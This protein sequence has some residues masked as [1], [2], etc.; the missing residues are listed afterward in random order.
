MK[1]HI[2]A[3]M[4]IFITSCILAG[5]WTTYNSKTCD[6]FATGTVNEMCEDSSGNMWFAIRKGGSN[7]EGGAVKFDGYEWST[8][9]TTN[10]GLVNNDV[11]TICVGKDNEMWY[12]TQTK[13]VSHFDK[14][15]WHTFDMF[16]DTTVLIWTMFRDSKDRVWVGTARGGP[17]YYSDSM[18][19]TFDPWVVPDKGVSTFY[20]DKNGLIYVAMNSDCGIR[21]YNGTSWRTMDTADGLP[22]NFVH[23]IYE[24]SKGRV[25]YG[26]GNGAAVYDNGSWNYFDTSNAPF[27]KNYIASICED[28]NGDMWFIA[29]YTSSKYG[30]FCYDGRDWTT[31]T[32]DNTNGGLLTPRLVYK[33][34][35]DYLWFASDSG[36]SRYKV[37]VPIVSKHSPYNQEKIVS[38][39][40]CNQIMLTDRRC[41]VSTIYNLHGRLL[42]KF[43][44]NVLDISDLAAGNYLLRVEYS[45]RKVF[46]NIFNVI[47]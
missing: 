42:K 9:D 41:Q 18:W 3:L 46:Q 17:M 45:G 31:Y 37:Y 5:E 38:S 13:G 47:R 21:I 11:M 16:N 2:I 24:D 43:N 36:A 8:L 12:G 4:T 22:S 28:P 39:I 19:T 32:N 29:F 20:E 6:G 25:W 1:K 14:H 15:G 27:W 35:K 26:T 34:S 33:D 40:T 7:P 23:V 30:A 10:S 44:K